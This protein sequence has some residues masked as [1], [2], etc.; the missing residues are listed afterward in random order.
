M[1]F[2]ISAY[3]VFLSCMIFIIVWVGRN[4]YRNGR[5]FI[6]AMLEDDATT[7][8]QINHLLLVGYYL[9]NIGYCFVQLQYW[10]KV[11]NVEGLI[12]GT[13]R[14]M[15]VLIFLLAGMHYVNM[16]VIHLISKSRTLSKSNKSCQS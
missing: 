8:D 5:I 11:A 6:L 10:E 4:F 13:G 12:A 16:M 2:N 3:A 9:F 7:T 1:N 15:G 14:K